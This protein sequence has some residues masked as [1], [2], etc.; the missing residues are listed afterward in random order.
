MQFSAFALVSLLGSAAAVPASLS[1]Q[2]I[3]EAQE[4]ASS[5][6]WAVNNWSVACGTNSSCTYSF[7]IEAPAYEPGTP[8][9]KASCNATGALGAPYQSCSVLN[10]TQQLV[11]ARIEAGNATDMVELAVSYEYVDQSTTGVYWNYTSFATE[12]YS[13]VKN[14]T[15]TPTQVAA[16]G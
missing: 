3:K 15:M 13:G 5:I 1:V 7:S 11:K 10:A 14:F 16:A 8:A 12:P 2:R 9:F 4:K 6:S